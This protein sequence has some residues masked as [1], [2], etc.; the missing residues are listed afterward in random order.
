MSRMQTR[1]RLKPAY[2]RP[3]PN[4]RHRNSKVLSLDPL[5][6]N[7]RSTGGERRQDPLTSDLVSTFFISRS[8][9][10]SS[11]SRARFL[12]VVA[13]I[14]ASRLSATA[15][16]VP[17][18]ASAFPSCSDDSTLSAAS[19]SSFLFSASTAALALARASSRP[20]SLAEDLTFGIPLRMCQYMHNISTVVI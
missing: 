1:L 11:S 3:E 13:S 17:V 4:D 12:P 5:I 19:C 10:S 2:H 18:V 20:E 16:A 15:L 8:A 7:D 14:S 6:Q 9:S